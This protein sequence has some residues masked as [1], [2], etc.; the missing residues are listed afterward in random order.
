[1]EN[2]IAALKQLQAGLNATFESYFSLTEK[3]PKNVKGI[4]AAKEQLVGLSQATMGTAL[5][6][7]FSMMG[8]SSSPVNYMA[9]R[10]AIDLGVFESIASRTSP[11]SLSQLQERSQADSTIIKRILRLVSALGFAKQTDI[12]H[13]EATPL[14][15]ALNDPVLKSWMIAHFDKRIKII[16]TFPEWLKA[17]QW[18]SSWASDDDNVCKQVVGTDLWTDYEQDP[19]ASAIF[20]VAMSMQEKFP[21]ETKPSYSFLADSKDMKEDADAVA[22]VDVGGG[23][24]QA[25]GTIKGENPQVPGKFILQD[26]P[27]TLEQLDSGRAKEIGF[28]PMVHNFFEPQPVKGAKYYH[29]RRVLHDWNDAK[30]LE[31]LEATRPALDPDYSRLLIHEFVLPDVNA[32][33]VESVIDLMMMTTLDGKERTEEDWYD[34]LGKAG[35]KIVNIWRAEVGTSA[36]IEAAVA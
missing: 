3:D 16:G 12:N 11:T 10:I 25:I 19:E 4:A 31:I 29:L 23:W 14:T 15:F 22:L 34:L 33:P 7:A 27:K 9:I 18:K 26:L 8:I 30:C 21:P 2:E 5:G 28:E 20:D 17:H 32:G 35:F 36:V 1:M 13:W 6:P 24:G